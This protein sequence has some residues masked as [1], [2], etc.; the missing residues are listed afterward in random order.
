MTTPQKQMQAMY[1]SCGEALSLA[2]RIGSLPDLPPHEELK[3][4]AGALLDQLAEKGAQA[5]LSRDDI[6]DARYAIVAFIDE[7]IFQSNWSGKQEWMLDPL[8]LAY[9]NETTAGEGFFNRLKELEA[10]PERAH[11]LQLYYL[12]LV[13]GF[14]GIYAVKNPESLDA[15]IES[16][17]VKLSRLLPAQD[18]FSPH[19]IPADSGR[20]QARKQLPVI[21]IA[22]VLVVLA[23]V[24]FAGLK[25]A[26]GSSASDAA[27][28]MNQTATQL[29]HGGAGENR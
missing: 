27:S 19:G 7:K 20:R 17:A 29:S 15:L 1:W 11:V 23:V 26:V 13:L 25:M 4:R 14:Q 10:R 22:I 2:A 9:F 3:L 28:N 18:V 24:G 5:G 16:I 8:Q 6:N 21:P 12:C